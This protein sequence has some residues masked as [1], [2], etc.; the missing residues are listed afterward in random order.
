MKA[1]KGIL[2]AAVFAALPLQ[3]QD[4]FIE[5]VTIIGDREDARAVA[6]SSRVLTATDLA[7]FQDT[8]IH[9]VLSQVPGVYMRKEEGYG[10]RPNISIRGSY[11]D[12]SSKITLM[13]DGV[14]IAPAPYTASSAYYFPTTGRIAGVEVLKGAAAIEN[15]PYTIGGAVNLLSTPVPQSMSGKL[16]AEGGADAAYKLHASYGGSAGNWGFLVEAYTAGTDGFSD[17]DYSDADTGF[18]K[19]D[20]LAKLRYST[21]G[22]RFYQQLDLKLQYSDEDSNQTYVG[23]TEADFEADSLRRYGMTRLD[24]MNNRHKSVNLSHLIEFSDSLSLTTTGYFNDFSRDWYKVDKIDEESID[25]VIICANGGSCVGMS[26][27]YGDYDRGFAAAVLHGRQMADVGVKHNNRDYESKGVQSR[28]AVYIDRGDWSH[29][30]HVGARYHEDFE[31]QYQP[32]DIYL[33]DDDGSLTF[34][35]VEDASPGKKASKA[36]SVYLTDEISSGAW[37][38]K[39]GLRY[40]DYIINGVGH[41]EILPGLGATFEF[42]DNWQLLA[43]IYEGHSPSPSDDSDPETATN[44]EAGFR[45]N[46][47]GLYAELI[48][49]FSDYDNIIGVCT[50][51]GGTGMQPCDAGDTENGGKAEIRGVEMVAGYTLDFSSERMPS[52]L[53][54]LESMPLTLSYTYT[55]AEFKYSFIG[56]SVW[57]EVRA[58]DKLPNLPEHQLML[59]VGLRLGGGFGGDLRLRYFDHTCAT[60]TCGEFDAIDAYSAIDLAAYYDWNEQA[61][62]YLNI[63]NLTDAEGDIVAREPKAG[64]RPQ[65]PRTF[66][67]GLRYQF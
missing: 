67:L 19:N 20:L 48:G 38:V 10:L 60:A 16:V 54:K 65:K 25:E 18:E 6:G 33:Q 28:L 58:G 27:A 51:S 44:Y 37:S 8:D 30:V 50:N 9:R 32:K 63:D 56:P 1:C 26:S 55:D 22:G 53:S 43:G 14:L 15:G 45:Y 47:G 7:R 42:A 40:E 35:R 66:M 2:L 49:F 13:E 31:A 46:G 12:R 4:K 36:W 24:N 34:N 5:T 62:F 64:A 23:L 59:A 61:R 29:Q 21:D 39:P 3:A 11:G 17:M 41:T 57:G 52:V